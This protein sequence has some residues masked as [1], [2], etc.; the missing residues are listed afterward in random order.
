MDLSIISVNWNS[1]EYMQECIAS[2]REHTTEITYEVVIVDNASRKED[3]EQLKRLCPE[4]T[5]L[6]SEENL[7]FARA[8]NLAFARSVGEYVLFLN[9]DTKLIGSAINIMLKEAKALPDAGIVG[10]KLLNRDLSVQ[11]SSIQKFPTIIN[12]VLDA[13]YLLLRW[14]RCPLWDIAPLF[15]QQVQPIKVDVISGACMLLRRAVFEQ[16]GKF[17]E[18]YFMYGEDTDLNFKVQGASFANYYVG[19]AE[20]VHYGGGSSSKQ[21][22][23]QWSVVM[24]HNSIRRYFRNTRGRYYELFY[25]LGMGSAAIVRLI[26]LGM[27]YP[28]GN[29]ISQRQALK[30]AMNKWITILRW[31]IGEQI[32]SVEG[33]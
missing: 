27:V 19:N 11:L 1:A 5:I 24:K 8:N 2:I 25:R 7:G 12:Q 30:N 28:W 21:C 33:S 13:E 3:F 20:I 15:S 14:P 6:R 26:A 31:A 18:D 29:L 9:P 16:V 22:W 23:N 32:C 17:R 10:C 4:A